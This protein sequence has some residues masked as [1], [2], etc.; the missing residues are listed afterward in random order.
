M[1]ATNSLHYQ[2]CKKAASF[3]RKTREPMEAAWKIIAV[4]MVTGAAEIPDVW[5]TN[6][7]QSVVVEV[8]TSRADFHADRKKRNRQ[9]GREEYQSGNYRYFLSPADVI[10]EDE[11]PEGWGLLHWD[12]KRITKVIQAPRRKVANRSDL[13]MMCSIL[14]RLGVTTKIFNFREGQDEDETADELFPVT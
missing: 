5:G 2:L 8:K 10:H 6:G 7:Y 3:L 4:E 1:S 13:L 9:S 14:R 11:L 12:G